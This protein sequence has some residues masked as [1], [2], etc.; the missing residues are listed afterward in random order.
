MAVVRGDILHRRHVLVAPF[1]LEAANAGIGQRFKVLAL[2]VI[3]NAQHM[4]VMR[5]DAPEAVLHRVRQA[6]FL[7]TV[8]AVGTPAG[9]R[10][11][12]ETLA[13]VGH[14][15]R[16]MD[17]ELQFRLL[18]FRG[19]GA[20]LLQGEFARQYQLRE[21]CVLQEPGLFGRANVSLGAGMQL[22][23]R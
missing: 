23:G 2:V 7:R 19:D 15:Q 18:H 3:L 21:P 14:A 8:A 11:A 10:M 13:A 6:T 17:E 22:D 1:N 9:V 5:H 20:D 12:N 4:L 16:A